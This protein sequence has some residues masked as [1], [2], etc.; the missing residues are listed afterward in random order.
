MRVARH[1]QVLFLSSTE[2]SNGDLSTAPPTSDEQEDEESPSEEEE[3]DRP[4]VSESPRT[5]LREK[6]Y[7]K[8]NN[9]ANAFKHMDKKKEGTVTVHVR[10]HVRVARP[11]NYTPPR[12]PCETLAA[13]MQRR[14]RRCAGVLRA[15]GSMSPCT[16]GRV[17]SRVYAQ[18]ELHVGKPVVAGD[19]TVLSAPFCLLVLA[20]KKYLCFC[21]L[22]SSIGC[23]RA[24]GFACSQGS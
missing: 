6:I 10:R 23:A 5:A 19:V 1:N 16:L 21:R 3:D 18:E 12:Y 24:P 7:D 11:V 20:T 8:Y 4:L 22:W 15:N 2:L 9:L 14:G 13:N 17:H